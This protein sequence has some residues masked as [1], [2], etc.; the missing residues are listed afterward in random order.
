[1]LR[2]L[3]EQAGFVAGLRIV[4][5]G[6]G[7]AVSIAIA[8]AFGTEMLGV[9]SYCIALM[10]LATVPISYGWSGM[11]LRSVAKQ[12]QLDG[13]SRAMARLGAIGGIAI[14]LVAAGLG[15]AAVFFG[16]SEIAE[17]VR[18]VGF[19]AVG[20]LAIALL[21]DQIAALR[22]A[23]LRGI[24][25]PA[26]AQLPE[27][28][29]RPMFLL[30]GI[31]LVWA[32]VGGESDTRILLGMFGALA[33]AAVLSAFVG[34]WILSR[35]TRIRPLRAVEPATRRMWLASAAALA[36]S[37]GLVQL[38]GYSDLLLLG[39]MRDAEEVGHY[40]AALQIAML[41]NFGYIALNMLAGQRF[42]NFLAQ[43]DK[44]SAAQTASHLSR[45][46]LLAAVPLPIVLMID[47]EW[48][49]AFLFGP[50]FE[51]AALPALIISLGIS[52]SAFVGMAHSL[53]IM[54]HGEFVAMRITACALAA[55]VGL[56]FVLIPQFGLIGAALS[57]AIANALWNLALWYF[58]RKVSGIDSSALGLHRLGD[59]SR[60][61]NP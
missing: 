3:V 44:A 10:T 25:R 34:Q 45:L 40:R 55:N 28:L 7:V 18:P 56:C 54:N 58:A 39:G 20:L 12:G 5:T 31:A 14:A 6:L 30:A 4:G 52:F 33:M 32:L 36:G 35:V 29:L 22:M 8:R 24:D 47:G 42:S 43:K 27:T 13:L 50:G 23:S 2:R 16:R 37:A 19:A 38:N 48:I 11:L 26:L 15:L 17:V 53:L 61:E 46:A 59:T 57:N 60:S 51:D 41:A 49:L 1:M 9:Y 21:S